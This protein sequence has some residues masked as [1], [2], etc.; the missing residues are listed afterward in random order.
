[1]GLFD[2]ITCKYPLPLPQFQ[3]ADFQTKDLECQM[4]CYEIRE[5]GTLW[6]QKYEIEDRSDPNAEGIA[7]LCG[8][9]SRVNLRWEPTKYTGSVDFYE[10]LNPGWVEFCAIF[11]DGKLTHIQTTEYRIEKPEGVS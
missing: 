6:M 11:I 10:W 5:D 3:G 9:L 7:R 1:M 8:M 2:T 4:D